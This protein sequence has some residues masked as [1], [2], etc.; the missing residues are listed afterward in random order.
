[1]KT[2]MADKKLVREYSRELIL[3]T[4]E[5]RAPAPVP[6]GLTFEDLIDICNKGQI[7]YL[8]MNSLMKIVTDEDKKDLMSKA[9]GCSTYKT[10]SQMVTAK[11]ISE[12]LEKEGVRHQLLK[13]SVTKLIYPAPEMREMSDVDLVS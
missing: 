10:F 3:A 5:R 9:L 1:M 12:A 4:F 13:G 8:F 11:A 6:E 2:Q 7:Q